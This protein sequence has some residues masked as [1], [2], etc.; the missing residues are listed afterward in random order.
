MRV[1]FD[2]SA[3]HEARLELL[4]SAPTKE[5][6]RKGRM[7]FLHTPIFLNEILQGYGCSRAGSR[8]REN[9]WLAVPVPTLP[10]E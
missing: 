6:R 4:R 1:L 3:L 10:Q 2:V 5:A 7:T 8:W 9:S